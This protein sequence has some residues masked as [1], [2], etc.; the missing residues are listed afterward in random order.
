MSDVEAPPVTEKE[1][2]VPTRSAG[3][4]LDR[5]VNSDQ[6]MERVET[7]V[8]VLERLRVASIK[9]T[10]PSD[11]IIHTSRD[12][13]G[14][15]VRQV[16]YLQ[17]SGAERAGKIWGIEIGAPTI[18]REE[19]PDKTYSYHMVA[20][21]WSKV[22]GERLDYV[23]GSRWSGDGFF[24]RSQGADDQI[25]PTDVRKSAYANLHGRA[26]RALSGLNGVPLDMLRAAG[27][28]VD[29]VVHVNYEKGAKGGDSAGGTVGGD[30]TVGFG[31]SKGKKP[32][33]LEDKDL[34]WYLKAYAENVADP[35]KANFLK[36][37]QR[38]LDA[39]K[40]EQERRTKATSHEAETGTKSPA[41]RG[42]KLSDMLARLQAAV[43]G[44]SRLIPAML[45]AITKEWGPEKAALSEFSD[46]EL[47]RVIAMSEDALK[48]VAEK[49]AAPAP[50]K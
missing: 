38:V 26:V 3:S 2:L 15:I 9:A 8:R 7:M 17:D 28:D 18:D 49:A 10:Y 36:A 20:D 1:T 11:W 4:L 33:E 35:R 34:A 45:R 21:A 31:N 12:A 24:K 39:L 19:F 32:A 42:E 40:A 37:N 50:E 14:G 27:V 46:A 30:V 13:D 22:T 48:A 43:G 5:W 16:G 29:K 23:E 41:T 25:D 44:Q 47:D 6:A